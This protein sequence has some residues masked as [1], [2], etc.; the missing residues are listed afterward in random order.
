MVTK[1]LLAVLFTILAILAG[2]GVAAIIF[3][4]YTIRDD[5]ELAERKSNNTTSE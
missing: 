3:I 1:I 5:R 2:I 4:I